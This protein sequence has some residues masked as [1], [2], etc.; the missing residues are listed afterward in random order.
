MLIQCPF[1]RT[2][3]RIPESKE[4]AKVRC[5]ECEKVY[6]ARA[7]GQRRSSGTSGLS[8]GIFVGAGILL[9][10]VFFFINRN[11]PTAVAPVVAAEEPEPEPV[12]DSTGWDSEPV[13]VVR[14]IYTAAELRDTGRLRNALH[15]ERIHGAGEGAAA[16]ST[17]GVAGVEGLLIA[18]IAS[19]TEGAD[20][21]LV[22]LWKPFDG[23]VM[24]ENDE[25]ATVRVKVQGRD[26]A[27][28][29]ETRTME[30]KL[31]R[32]PGG[33][34][35]LKVWSWERYFTPAELAA[36]RR[37]KAKEVQKVTLSDGSVV[38]ES[39]PRPLGHLDDTPDDLRKKI[40]AEYERM[41]DFELRPTENAA[42]KRELEAIGR[43][44]IPILLTGL[45]EIPLE[46]DEHAMKVNLINQALEEIT[47]NYTGWKPM[48][49][50]GSGAGTTNERRESAIK[51]W[52]AWWLRKGHRFEK[53]KE[54][55]DLL[56]DL[57]VP[58][59]RDLR[60]MERDKS[61]SG[62]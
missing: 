52:F 4:G 45:Y 11:K 6:T 9:A 3:A 10:I 23:E 19:L 56:E 47:G 54:Q 7:P 37:N 17:L 42:A 2:Q 14:E 29:L 13:R 20:E 53:K 16:F 27:T 32:D 15:L 28:S 59:E 60:Q 31:A 33:G 34:G 48:V 55:K 12:V 22:I 49:A 50:E 58:T 18:T 41:L 46:T 8:I 1:C 62:G 24:E 35:R 38:F 21:D 26:A 5:G 43:P 36:M 30:F 25:E 51:Q 61:S 40:D 44:A 39:K 57:I